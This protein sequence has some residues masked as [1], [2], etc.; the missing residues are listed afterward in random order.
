MKRIL[1]IMIC[2]ALA[3]SLCA[4]GRD[5]A[6]TET[7]APTE[8]V[9]LAPVDPTPSGDEAEAASATEAEELAE[10]APASSTD[11][12]DDAAAPDAEAYAAA[13]ACVGLTLEELYAAVGEPS[14][15]SY[16]ASC[17]E[18]NAEDGMLF[19]EDLGFYVWTVRS[20]SGELV[21]AV[22]SLYDDP[23]AE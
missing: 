1:M 13:Q 4:C 12:D 10:A 11:A 9:D 17:L 2:A 15:T 18:E 3:V 14:R 7:P 6:P 21:H 5:A 8:S 22:Y 23:A 20:E 16:A 19:Y